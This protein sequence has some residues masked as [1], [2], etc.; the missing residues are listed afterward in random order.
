M[1]EGEEDVD[2]GAFVGEAGDFALSAEA[3]GGGKPAV[4]ESWRGGYDFGAVEEEVV[5]ALG[6][7]V[8]VDG[9]QGA[10]E[11]VGEVFD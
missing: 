2:G 5:G 7:V 1:E 3:A 8:A 9:A 6:V 10:V 4:E 11:F